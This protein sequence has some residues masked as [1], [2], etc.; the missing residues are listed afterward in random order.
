[1]VK[2]DRVG[3]NGEKRLTR[4]EALS[5]AG[6]VAVGVFAAGIVGGVAG[7]FAGS[8]A[9]PTTTIT[10]TRR[11]TVATTIT[12][13]KTVMISPT[14]TTPPSAVGKEC[15]VRLRP[16]LFF[17]DGTPLTAHDVVR[18]VDRV[19]K[20]KGDPAWFVLDFLDDWKALDDSTVKF[21]LK[22]PVAFFPAILA[23]PTYFPVHPAYKPDEIDS[24]QTAGGAGPYKIVK[25]TRDVE[26]V[27]EA[28]PYWFA[29]M[30]KTKQVIVRFY[31]DATA[32]RMALEAGEID[33]AWRTLRPTDIQDLKK[34]EEI[35]VLEAPG[36]AIRYI[37]F[38]MHIPPFDDPRVRKA[39]AAALD[40][41][42]ICEKVY[43]GTYEP[44]YSMVPMG[45]WSHKNS[46][47]EKYGDR[48]LELARK[49]LGEAGYSPSNKLRIELWYTPTHYGDTEVDVATMIKQ[50]W[51]ETGM[52][53]VEL[54][55]AEW[56]TYLDYT[57]KRMLGASLYGWYPDYIDPDDYTSPFVNEAG[58]WLGNA[59]VSEELGKLLVEARTKTSIEERTALYER[60]QDI[61]AEDAVIVPFAQG[62]LEIAYRKGV[63]GVVLDPTLL[64]RYWLI[65]KE[66]G[67]KIADR[68]I[69]GVTDKVSDLDPAN[70]YDFFTWEVLNNIMT[71]M[72][73]YIPGTTELELGLAASYSLV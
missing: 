27:L 50:Q 41:K 8:A 17:A 73:R 35:E 11:E 28:N 19:A 58:R 18:S 59:Y 71:G 33:I 4:R 70:A 67:G 54:K 30:P 1:M 57:R 16:G 10:E 55:S 43:F 72:M 37:V 52:V 24:D 20:I 39:L 22:E 6:K 3:A 45:M 40:R 36:G 5:T 66:E 63:K 26:L 32:L 56:T 42:A 7:Y 31:K 69:I 44:L 65:Y 21:T 14:V 13:T 47:K 60:I 15:I 49:L 38:N 46:F 9:A 53:E 29:G 51:E 12:S 68:I 64:L 34:K 61:W 2:K 23:V 48:N 62:K 25:W